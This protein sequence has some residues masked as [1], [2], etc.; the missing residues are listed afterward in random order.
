V[1]ALAS[2]Q[3]RYVGEPAPDPP[4][5]ARCE[6][7]VANTERHLVP[8]SGM[9]SGLNAVESDCVGGRANLL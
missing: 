8:T 1:L 5:R 3:D 6:G 7:E 2:T 4:I 9:S